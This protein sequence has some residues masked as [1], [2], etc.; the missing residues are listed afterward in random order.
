M[1]VRSVF[2]GSKLRIVG[3]VFLL[4]VGGIA[5]A[6]AGGV[7]GVP[8]VQEMQNSFGTVNES[9]TVIRTNVS[10]HNPNP[11]GISL[12][13][14]GLNYTVDMNEVQL[15]SGEKHGVGIGSGNGTVTLRTLMDNQQIP[16]WWVSHIRNGER[17]SVDVS[18]TISSSTLGQRYTTSLPSRT[19]ATD[20]LSAFNSTEQ[21]PIDAN[22]PLVQDPVAYV[23]ETSASWG[24]VTASETPTEMRF[25][26]YNPKDYAIT[27]SELGYNVT[28]AGVNVGEGATSDP[29]IIEPNSESTIE[30]DVV[31]D[32]TKLDDWWVAHLQADQTSTLQIS[33]YVQVSVGGE[34]IRLPLDAFTHEEQIETDILGSKSA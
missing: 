4:L 17:T 24:T 26:V 8:Q 21:R 14:V 5:A 3:T 32:A 16:K 23:N 6:Y 31:I 1:S 33:F 22:Q 34:T 2:L 18:A 19:I 9:T 15:A 13:G 30:A 28:M 27:V 25:V 11:F 10:V 29:V 7:I 12:G 20:L